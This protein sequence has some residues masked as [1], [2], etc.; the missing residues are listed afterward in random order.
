MII[1]PLII[2]L[3]FND[4]GSHQNFIAALYS[5]QEYYQCIAELRRYSLATGADMDYSIAFCYYKGKRFSEALTVLKS[6]PDKDSKHYLLLANI[7]TALQQYTDALQTLY[8]CDSNR[9]NQMQLLLYKNILTVHVAH[10]DW[11]NALAFYNSHSDTLKDMRDIF[12]LL[13]KAKQEAK[14]PY[15]AAVLSAM[16]PGSG[17]VYAH[18]Y[19]D[20][21][22]SF[23]TVAALAGATYLSYAKGNGGLMYTFGTLTTIG[24]AGNVYSAYT[25]TLYSNE[26][27][28]SN[29]RTHIQNQFLQYSLE[30][31]LPEWM[32]Q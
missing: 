30:I 22:I 18:H 16:V 20:G 29:Y 27:M 21:I 10:Y 13:N 3:L 17:H 1:V 5:Q 15:M 19:T 9:D 26:T 11:D 6:K 8:M 12:S 4:T 24:Y 32:K 25:S 31:F 23:V 7:Y 28:N 14:N 2:T